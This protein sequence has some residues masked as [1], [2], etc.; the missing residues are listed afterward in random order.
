MTL[1]RS[2]DKTHA[3]QRHVS[4]METSTAPEGVGT[5]K[6]ASTPRPADPSNCGPS[7][8]GEDL[9][10]ASPGQG[11]AGRARAPRGSERR[12]ELADRRVETLDV[13]QEG[14]VPLATVE[15]REARRDGVVLAEGACI[16][17][18]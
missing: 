18:K 11:A 6:G 16:I 9:N 7:R 12:E 10:S 17:H 2:A 15:A 4:E 8:R 13:D 5:P 1:D 3:R 14:V